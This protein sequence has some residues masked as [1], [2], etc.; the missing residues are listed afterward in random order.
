MRKDEPN[1]ALVEMARESE[2]FFLRLSQACCFLVRRDCGKK[3]SMQLIH[4]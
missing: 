3:G 4:W 2:D 1:H